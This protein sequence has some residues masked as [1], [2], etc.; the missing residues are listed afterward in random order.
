[1]N[2][3]KNILKFPLFILIAISNFAESI[4]F[5]PL[6]FDTEVEARK[7]IEDNPSNQYNHVL[8]KRKNKFIVYQEVP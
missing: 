4:S 7:Y 3:L 6:V 5:T 1:M 2:F 8:E